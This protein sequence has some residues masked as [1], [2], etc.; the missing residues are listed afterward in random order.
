MKKNSGAERRLHPRID[1]KLPVK[2]AVNGYDFVTTT[3]NISCLGAC[4][5]VDKY[6]PPFTRILIKMTIPNIDNLTDKEALTYV[7]CKGVIV[8]TEDKKGGG[9][10]IAIFFNHIRQGERQKISQ[11]ISRQT[12]IIPSVSAA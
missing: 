10:N 6:I 8:R 11:L 5:Q 3:Q 12:S 2:I 1:H 7:D 9:F 4:C